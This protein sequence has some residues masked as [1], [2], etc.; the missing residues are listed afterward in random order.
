M[1]L[2]D[3][4]GQ[5]FGRLVIV[6]ATN[7]GISVRWI[8]RCDCGNIRVINSANLRYGHTT[9]CGCRQ[10]EIF[11]DIKTTHGHLIGWRAG[12]REPPEYTSWRT[13]KERC[14]SPTNHAYRDYGG[15]GITVCDAWRDNF[16]QFF[17][18]MGPRPPRH[19]LD[20]INNAGNYEPT[21]CRWVSMKE[22]SRNRR[23]TIVYTYKG[24][25]KCLTDWAIKHGLNVATLRRR[26]H[27]GL[28]GVALFASISHG[29][30]PA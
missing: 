27:L 6:G 5:R 19:S 25:T 3:L 12:V 22:Q 23:S 20:R 14:F 8:A 26:W 28:R 2:I 29:G 18:D 1:R 7:V 13:M 30:H 9:S 4:T 17:K 24:E 10:R 16:Q 11:R 21:N 15:R